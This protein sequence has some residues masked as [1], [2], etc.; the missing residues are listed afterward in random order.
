MDMFDWVDQAGLENAIR[1]AQHFSTLRMVNL[2]FEVVKAYQQSAETNTTKMTQ[3]FS[4][5]GALK[6]NRNMFCAATMSDLSRR[7]SSICAYKEV[8]LELI[9]DIGS[10]VDRWDQV[11]DDEDDEDNSTHDNGDSNDAFEI[12]LPDTEKSLIGTEAIH[13]LDIQIARQ[14]NSLPYRLLKYVLG[15]YPHL[16]CLHLDCTMMDYRIC[17]SPLGY[18]HRGYGYRG[19][20]ESVGCDLSYTT[21]ENIQQIR[22]E[23]F[24]PTQEYLDLLSRSVPN[25][26]TMLFAD[27]GQRRCRRN[28]TRDSLAFDFDLTGFAQLK[29]CHFDLQSLPSADSGTFLLIPVQYVFIHLKYT[30]GEDAYNCLQHQGGEY[31]ACAPI[32]L[33]TM[34]NHQETQDLTM[35]KLINIKCRKLDVFSFCYGRDLCIAEIHQGELQ[36][37]VPK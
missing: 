37:T 32:D 9:Y 30:D 35:T 4:L 25:V 10:E 16:G 5:F 33:H 7:E 13:Y 19:G 24:L 6:R 22:F 14:H 29:T 15:N 1:F 17:L 21:Q 34:Q 12:P 27:G 36:A 31:D 26:T 2:G 8:W 3:L 11:S 20:K 23:G 28:D 18:Q